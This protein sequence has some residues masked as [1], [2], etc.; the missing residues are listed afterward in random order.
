MKTKDLL[1]QFSHLEY[2]LRDFSLELLSSDEIEQLKTAFD[3][4]KILLDQK[5]RAKSQSSSG[6]VTKT[7]ES[8]ST[9]YAI[10]DT[11][12][13]AKL[14]A[15]VSHELRTPLNGII[16]FADLLKEDQL[17]TAQREQVSAIQSA[18]YA[19]IDIV[20]ELLEYSKLS[21][22]MA[23]FE[24]VD[25]NLNHLVNDVLYLCN[26][27]VTNNE[28]HLEAMIDTRIPQILLGDPSKLSQVL[29]N[30]IGN[31][32]KFV[33]NGSIQLNIQLKH[34]KADTYVLEFTISDM[35]IGIS[36]ANLEH[37]FELFKQAESDTHLKYGGTGIG[38]SIVKELIEQ[39]EG[40]I[41]VSSKLGEGTTFCF[42]LPYAKGNLNNIKQQPTKTTSENKQRALKGLKILVF[43]DNQLNQKLIEQRLKSW[44]CVV[45][46]TDN[47]LYGLNIL[48]TQKIDLVLTDIKMPN[49]NGFEISTHL[50]NHDNTTISNMPIIALSADLE[51]LDQKKCEAYQINDFILKPFAADELLSKLLKYHKKMKSTL[52]LT[53]KSINPEK[54]VYS[55]ATKVNL[56]MLL[57]ECQGKMNLLEELI[58]LYKQ[59]ALEFMGVV[60]LNLTNE[61]LKEI[62]FAAHKIK[63]GLVMMQ[64]ESLHSIVLQIENIAKVNG[65][66][67]HLAFLYDCF[68]NEY[69]IVEKAIETQVLALKKQC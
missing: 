58:V 42:S 49:K 47:W 4:C 9:A 13:A 59:N 46:T 37:I 24:S 38:L 10:S 8:D 6:K 35:G 54:A 57:E 14:V 25:F 34:I 43:E 41:S 66:K 62:A 53:S 23:Q 12:D 1:S 60:R 50:R 48:E 22:G 32:I 64:S 30:L 69:P 20:N 27:L 29:L 68:V 18:S 56:S 7:S 65:D 44:G 28:V 67:K 33:E 17:S 45:F 19:L 55:D 16:G 31:A 26:T 39:Q 61:N 51:T 63:S 11:H 2:L 15:Y 52:Q 40:E 5:I 21:A 36:K 3:G